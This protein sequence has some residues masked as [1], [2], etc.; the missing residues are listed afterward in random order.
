MK[1]KPGSIFLKKLFIVIYSI[2]SYTLVYGQIEGVVYDA[3]TNELLPGIPIKCNQKT[4]K[5]DIEGFFRIDTLGLLT[6]EVPGY[7]E[8]SKNFGK[9][10]TGVNIFLEPLHQNIQEIT[11]KGPLKE[12]K[13]LSVPAS[14]SMLDSET[15][16]KSS[17]ISYLE[18]LSLLS[19]VFIHNGTLNTNRITIRGMG[20]RTPYGTNRVKAFYNDVPLTSADGTTNI[21]DIDG[22]LLNRIDVLKGPKSAV[23]GAGLGGVIV[24]TGKEQ[25]EDG[26]QGR[27]SVEG[28]NFN[29]YK[30]SISLGFK[31][32][33]L[34]INTFYSY[35]TSDGFRENSSYYRHS[36]QV[37]ITR[38]DENSCTNLLIHF[39]NLKAF[40]PSSINEDDFMNKPQSA[41]S[42]WLS[43]KGFEEYTKVIGSLTNT[44]NFNEKLKNKLILSTNI[45]DAYESRPFNI[46]DDKNNRIGL[47]DYLDYSSKNIQVRLGFELIKEQY[48]W[49][50]YETISGIEGVLLN[51]FSENR[52]YTALFADINWKILNEKLAIESGL[53]YSFL[54][55]ELKDL[56]PGMDDLSGTFDY[57]PIAA[58]FVGINYNFHKNIYLYSSYS[59][60]FSYPSVEE[61]LLPDGQINP[62]L[63]P[64][65]GHCFE[66]GIRYSTFDGNLFI[67]VGGYY[68]MVDNLLVTE[69]ITED[70]F[71]GKNLGST[72]HKGIEVNSSLLL[73]KLE[74][75]NFPQPG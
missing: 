38:K 3:Q 25:K 66:V 67:D 15:L 50:I 49:D 70:I 33:Q 8:Y 11:I 10:T 51:S 75:N 32:G 17:G 12:T 58:P 57:E 54:N 46:L 63:Q 20:S 59:Y 72:T 64:E 53:S 18:K 45:S 26:F 31:K 7:Q 27:F 1:S 13:L 69:R 19:G 68:F 4:V 34:S 16:E 74:E 5:T 42:N 43:V 23:Y 22:S 36:G 14:I 60:G 41:A 29:S 30:P 55:Y 35:T 28:G 9:K 40:I 21:E 2:G 71:T 73:N 61:T 56:Q 37:K 39:I 6:I 24:L 44:Y 52:N 62:D 65:T 47:K 48:D